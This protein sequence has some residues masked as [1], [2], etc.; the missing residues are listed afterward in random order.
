LSEGRTDL[1][2]QGAP[3]DDTTKIVYGDARSKFLQ[4]FLDHYR[5]TGEKGVYANNEELAELT[6]IDPSDTPRYLREET[7]AGLIKV[8]GQT[9]YDRPWVHLTKYAIRKYGNYT[10]TTT[11]AMNILSQP[12][13]NGYIRTPNRWS[14]EMKETADALMR[15]SKTPQKCHPHFPY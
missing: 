11:I 8:Y 15:T 10:T 1:L 7:N 4:F 3:I 14:D 5:E 2:R 13:A 6:G 9:R 12:C